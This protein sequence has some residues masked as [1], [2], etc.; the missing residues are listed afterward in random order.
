MKQ[1]YEQNNSIQPFGVIPEQ[2]ISIQP[3]GAP[4]AVNTAFNISSTIL[5]MFNGPAGTVLGIYGKIIDKLWPE[6]DLSKTV[7][8]TDMM[9]YTEELVNQKLD[10]LVLLQAESE[11]RGLKANIDEYKEALESYTKNVQVYGYNSPITAE[12]QNSLVGKIMDLNTIF[13]NR[14]TAAFTVNNYRSILLPSYACAATLHLLYLRELLVDLDPIKVGFSSADI[15]FI[16]NQLRIRTKEYTDYCINTYNDGLNSQKQRGWTYFNKYRREMTFLVLDL[17]SLFQIYDPSNYRPTYDSKGYISSFDLD[18][19]KMGVKTE[20]TREVHTDLITQYN[21]HFISN[22][23]T[24]NENRFIGAP[25]IF[26]WLEG[27]SCYKYGYNVSG[28][29]FD[30]LIGNKC[31][32]SFS[33]KGT[34]SFT[35]PFFGESSLASSSFNYNFSNRFC[36]KINTNHTNNRYVQGSITQMVASLNGSKIP[37]FDGG[38]NGAVYSNE[39]SIDNHILSNIKTFS[40]GTNS[41]F[42]Y[43]FSFT[44]DKVDPNNTFKADMI[45]Q[46]PVVKTFTNNPNTTVIKGPGFTG[47]DIVKLDDS[48]SGLFFL[49]KP[50]DYKASNTKFEVRVRYASKVSN[51]LVL[52]LNYAAVATVNVSPTVKNNRPLTDLKYEDFGYASFPGFFNLGPEYRLG[53]FR[54]LANTEIVIDKIELIPSLY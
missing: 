9:K 23:H 33:P 43:I 42:G 12:S 28:L 41:T 22:D 50:Y 3:F 20:L 17:V 29:Y 21:S 25:H 6:N 40:S 49:L 16:T 51:R 30:T 37:L 14:I 34:N 52:D 36:T 10:E 44:H 26:N 27:T 1:N 47:G 8:W 15:H 19:Y 38:T 53:L 32:M 24:S 11:I 5:G 39:F 18:L 13:I 7:T 46:I 35:S 2:E 48:T 4:S 31:D 45:T 54:D